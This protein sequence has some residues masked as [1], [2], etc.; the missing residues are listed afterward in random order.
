MAVDIG[1]GRTNAGQIK[2][3]GLDKVLRNLNAMTGKIHGKTRKGMTIV[4][5]KIRRDAQILTPV[6]TG[7]LR[8]SAYTIVGGGKKR[9]TPAM[10]KVNGAG[11]GIATKEVGLG[12]FKTRDKSGAR[13]AIEHQAVIDSKKKIRKNIY[14]IVGF[15]AHYALAVHERVNAKGRRVR[16]GKKKVGNKRVTLKNAQIGQAKFL[17]ESLLKN[18]KFIL[19]TLK[20]TAKI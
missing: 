10:P 11:S 15:T 9:V 18:R 5:L 17:E 4:T 2:W 1:R 20:E 14:G 6:D 19:K 12:R 7:N 3:K 16:T 8:A 13:V